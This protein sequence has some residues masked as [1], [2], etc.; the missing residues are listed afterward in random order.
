[1][2]K[3][4]Y[5]FLC[6]L[7]LACSAEDEPGTDPGPPVAKKDPTAQD[8]ELTAVENEA[9]IFNRA[10]LLEN[11]EL[12][13]NAIIV[14]V[15]AETQEGGS[16]TDNRDNTYTYDP[17]LDYQG[18][19]SFSY[20]ICVPGDSERC[21][22]ATVTIAVG[23]A[24]SPVAVD[25]AYQTEEDKPYTI[26]NYLDN[27]QVVD[28]AVV[29]EVLSESGN[30]TV[31]LQEDGSI[32]YTPNQGFSGEDSFTYTLC[33]DD[34]TPNCSTATITMTVID[35]GSPVA[36]DDSRVVEIGSGGI[37]FKRL[38]DNDDLIDDA[39]ITSVNGDGISGQVTL[40]NDGSVTYI[41]AAGFSGE[42]TFTYTICD[43]D[44]EPTCSTA[45]VTINVVEAVA[46]D[47]PAGLEDYYS[48]LVF[49]QDSDLLYESLSDFST[50]MHTN[51]LEYSD[52]HDYLY[53]ADAAL[54]DPS[55]VVLIYSGELRPDDEYQ[56]G[57]LDGDESFNTEHIYPQSLLNTEVSVSDL[58][59]LRVADAEVNSE[60]LNYPFVDGS[61]TYKLVNGN[62][63]FPGDDWR[64]DV[65]RM[66]MYVNLRYGDSFD[67]VGTLELFLKWNREDP[68]SDFEIQRNN[69]IEG[70]QGNRNPFID[71]PYLATII[72]G[73]EAAE[74][75]WE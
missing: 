29:T 31:V 4:T 38:L 2:K 8:D 44:A 10:V 68:V 47:I 57:D 32:V 6:L 3:L 25:D 9:Y 42:E 52:R 43:D 71:N 34:E 39:Q 19:D 74:N 72:W 12:I 69:V 62:S 50:T 27:D 66:V 33:D 61:G 20:T 70:A 63:W 37:N 58:H 40:E 67:E 54:N 26:I 28:N 75:R 21:S 1:M 73:G 17:P 11:D 18:E 41:P 7:I 56:I 55:M 15:D 36:R 60:R 45:N 59:L 13:D 23:D 35:T 53:D 30:S 46:F 49:T 22:T 64:G 14:S 5:L 16:I 24:G 51:R 65:A 48:E